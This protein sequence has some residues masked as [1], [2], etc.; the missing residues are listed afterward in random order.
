MHTHTHPLLEARVK[1]LMESL[2]LMDVAAAQ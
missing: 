1:L 2:W